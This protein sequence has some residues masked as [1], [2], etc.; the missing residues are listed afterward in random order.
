MENSIIVSSIQSL[1]GSLILSVKAKDNGMTRGYNIE[2]KNGIVVSVLTGGSYA[3]CGE[4]T[5]EVAVMGKKG[6]FLLSNGQTVMGYMPYEEA[7]SLILATAN[8]TEEE[9]K[10]LR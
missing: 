9:I 5:V 10:Q 7:V 6:L 3:Y 2:L 1:V 8:L 4:G